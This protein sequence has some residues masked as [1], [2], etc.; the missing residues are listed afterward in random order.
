MEFNKIELIK[1]V[2][3]LY[4]DQLG[5]VVAK[6]LVEKWMTSVCGVSGE[7]NSNIYITHKDFFRLCLFARDVVNG[8]VRFSNGHFY[9]EV[10]LPN[11]YL[12]SLTDNIL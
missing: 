10:L 3:S 9:T 7:F 1:V 5:I 11:D 2:R 12:L 4:P 6:A 8:K